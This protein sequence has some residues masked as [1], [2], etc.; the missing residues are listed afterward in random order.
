MNYCYLESPIGALL[1]VGDE[2]AVHSIS[3]PRNGKP[4]RPEAGWTESKPIAGRGA[5]GLAVRQLREYFAGRRTEFDFPM[6]PKGTPFQRAVWQRLTE[7]PYGET[8]SYGELARRVGNPKAARA[9]GA[10]NR[11]NPLPIV[12]PCHR[13]IGANGTLTGFGGGLPVKEALLA[14]ETKA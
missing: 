7:I 11:A 4:K 3:F 6:E 2:R 12:V 5:L 9:V 13:V 10:A 14:L 8:I 1:I